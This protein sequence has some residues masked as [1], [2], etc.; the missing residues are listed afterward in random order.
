MF[1]NKDA[2][3]DEILKSH[4][5]T[6]DQV[7]SI[8]LVVEKAMKEVQHGVEKFVA[9]KLNDIDDEVRKALT[10]ILRN[11]DSVLQVARAVNAIQLD[12]LNTIHNDRQGMF[13]HSLFN[14]YSSDDSDGIF[15]KIV[16]TQL[17]VI[18]V[19]VTDSESGEYTVHTFSPDSGK[20][21]Q[22]G[23]DIAR[24]GTVLINGR[25]K[26]C[27]RKYVFMSEYIFGKYRE[28][29]VAEQVSKIKSTGN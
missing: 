22:A 28:Y 7:L 3:V 23:A 21:E 11:R 18:M 13:K 27:A 2:L 5:V 6:R 1:V 14:G 16:E 10:E 20:W 17:D 15:A 24:I 4:N 12:G 25:E 19:D 8:L 29:L 26:E 9:N